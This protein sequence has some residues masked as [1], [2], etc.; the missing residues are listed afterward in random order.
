LLILVEIQL[1]VRHLML[2]LEVNLLEQLTTI[3]TLVMELLEVAL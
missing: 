3:G 2:L 1:P